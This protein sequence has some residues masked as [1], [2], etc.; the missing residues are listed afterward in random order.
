LLV[1][2]VVMPRMSGR[3]LAD[4]LTRDRPQMRILFVSG[5]ADEAITRYGVPEAGGAFLQKP[6]NP[7]RLA[8]K[9]REVLDTDTAGG[10]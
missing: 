3:Q 5:N 8:Q 1:T 6:F 4:Q 2:D 9:V 10:R 7:V